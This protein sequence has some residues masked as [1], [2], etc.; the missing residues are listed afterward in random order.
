MCRELLGHISLHSSDRTLRSI[1]GSWWFIELLAPV[2]HLDSHTIG[3]LSVTFGA[4]LCR[5]AN[6]LFKGAIGAGRAMS[7]KKGHEIYFSQPFSSFLFAM[8][9][10]NLV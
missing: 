9:K 4:L 7:N 5:D 3:A 6:E 8:L 1:T 10:T 2:L